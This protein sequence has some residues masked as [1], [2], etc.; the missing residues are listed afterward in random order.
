MSI[1]EAYFN[2]L[3]AQDNLTFTLSE[4]QAISKQL[5][6][7]KQRFDVG[8]IAITDVYEAQAGYD[9]ATANQIEAVNLLDDSK[10]ALR[11]LIGDTEA[12][13]LQLHKEIEFLTLFPTTLQNGL[14]LL[15]LIT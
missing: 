4:Q 8:L 15:K 3:S 2:I 7:A 13:L 9:L 12:N 6:Q 10:E 11:E 5:E 1:T 14:K